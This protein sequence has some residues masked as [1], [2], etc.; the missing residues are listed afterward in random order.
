MPLVKYGADL[1]DEIDN[2]GKLFPRARQVLGSQ[3]DH[4]DANSSHRLDMEYLSRA[5]CGVIASN[6]PFCGAVGALSRDVESSRESRKDWTLGGAVVGLIPTL[7]F[8]PVGALVLIVPTLT[9][10]GWYQKSCEYREI[11]ESKRGKIS[12]PINTN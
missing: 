5:L 6:V 9:G 12:T 10:C 4:L 2:L 8:W 1:K 7:V 11:Q 3:T